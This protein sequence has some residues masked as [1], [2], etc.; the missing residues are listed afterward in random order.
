[1]N[2]KSVGTVVLLAFVAVSVG[3]LIVSE[4]RSPATPGADAPATGTPATKPAAPPHQVVAYYFHN[5]QRCMTCNKIERLA[6]EALREAFAG[7]LEQGTL[8]WRTVNME[9]PPNLHYIEDY[10]LVTSS[11]VLVDLRD[12][13]QRDWTNLE[14]VWQL[15]HED[16]AEFKRYVA[17]AARRY[18]ESDA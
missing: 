13:E 1:M 8:E 4:T 5:T 14:K 10:E 7:P 15:V 2:A 3:Y 17:E 16:E 9:R 12:G 18:L 11:V 6:E